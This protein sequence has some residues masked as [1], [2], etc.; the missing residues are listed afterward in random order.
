MGGFSSAAMLSRPS[1]KSLCALSH[2]RAHNHGQSGYVDCLQDRQ[3]QIVELTL[4]WVLYRSYTKRINRAAAT[5][6]GTYRHNRC[7]GPHPSHKRC[8]CI[9]GPSCTAR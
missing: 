4:Y 2:L 7:R 6:L 1:S 3:T 5:S 8:S 9:L